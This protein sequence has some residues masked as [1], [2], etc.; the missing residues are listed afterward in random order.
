MDYQTTFSK[1][2]TTLSSLSGWMWEILIGLVAILF[3]FF[4][5]KLN[6]EK[7]LD[8]KIENNDKTIDSAKKII[9][10]E[11]KNSDLIVDK[12]KK[13]EQVETIQKSE[14]EKTVENT[15]KQLSISDKTDKSI[16]DQYEIFS[17]IWEN[18]QKEKGK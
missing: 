18:L 4:K 5:I 10:L 1:I 15:V 12:I 14:I 6:S 7:K 9:N 2:K 17:K 13:D 11:T 16:Q 8:Q 3:I